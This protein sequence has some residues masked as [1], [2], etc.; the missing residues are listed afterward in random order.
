VDFLFEKLRSKRVIISFLE[1][2]L[3]AN[4]GLQHKIEIEQQQKQQRILFPVLIDCHLGRQ[5]IQSLP[6]VDSYN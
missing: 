2:A 3:M 5:Q 6:D 1:L 4:D